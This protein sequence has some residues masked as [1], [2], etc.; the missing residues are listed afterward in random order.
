M[1][2]SW[3][4]VQ[5]LFLSVGFLSMFGVCVAGCGDNIQPELETPED[6]EPASCPEPLPEP[7]GLL[8]SPDELDRTLCQPGAMADVDAQGLWYMTVPR[9]SFFASGGPVRFERCGGRITGKMGFVE[10]F[11]LYVTRDDDDLF[12]RQHFDSRIIAGTI[13]G[14]DGQGRLVGHYEVCFAF[15]DME[16]MCERGQLSMVPFGPI[17]G[18]GRS[19]GLE[20]VSAW[21]GSEEAPWDPGFDAN[22]RV[23]DGVAY[24]VRG[25][26]GLRIIDVRDPAKPRDLGHFPA[27]SDNFND[28][29]VVDGPDGKRYALVASAV[30]GVVVVD[31][32]HPARPDRVTSF[33]TT[34]PSVGAHTLFT[35]TIG[36]VTYAYVA[37][38]L[39]PELG[40]FDVTD[41]AIPRRV[42]GYTTGNRDWEVHDLH[43]S[44]GRAYLNAALGGL[45]V[46][47]TQPDPAAP[48]LVGQFMPDPPEYSHSNWVTVAGGK[49]IAVHGDEGYD[50]HLTIVDVDPASPGFMQAIGELSLRD[51]VSVHNIMAVGER[52]YV[53]WYQDG[54]RVIDLRDPTQ[55]TQIAHY[56]TWDPEQSNAAFF[57]GAV[58]LDVHEDEGL[59]YAA[60][61]QQGLVILRISE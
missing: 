13:C 2:K 33:S 34:D 25:D 20:L 44:G 26:D 39:T 21:Q 15:M 7:E 45:I 6:S 19:Q 16:P 43:V 22:V 55:P 8:V 53:A 61:T 40:I 35:E 38:A 50:A 48:V 4:K 23:V 60:D 30:H 47:D 51:E 57:E 9:D 28:V 32:T 10:S 12:F 24:L 14:R 18:E 46:V 17:P 54:I 5:V 11:P 29:K 58:G 59:I 27:E 56:N 49:K 52:A 37:D 42:G 41:P 3:T 31:V 1:W 36:D